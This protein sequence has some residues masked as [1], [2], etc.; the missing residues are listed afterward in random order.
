MAFR[1]PHKLGYLTPDH[2]GRLANEMLLGVVAGLATIAVGLL[3]IGLVMV[4]G[5]V[6]WTPWL[7]PFTSDVDVDEPL[8]RVRNGW[9]RIFGRPPVWGGT[10]LRSRWTGMLPGPPRRRGGSPQPAR[11]S[12]GADKSETP[13]SRR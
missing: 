12:A 7:G 9:R 6:I 2:A 5:I 1:D 3:A 10:P 8:A 4:V 11:R 13:Q